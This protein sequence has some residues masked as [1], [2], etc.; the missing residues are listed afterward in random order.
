MV[1]VSPAEIVTSPSTTTV[2]D[3]W[4]LPTSSPDQGVGPVEM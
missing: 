1:N 3:Q 4:L 2:P